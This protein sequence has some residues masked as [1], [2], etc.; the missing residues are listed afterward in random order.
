MNESVTVLAS[1]TWIVLPSVDLMPVLP[2]EWSMF[3]TSEVAFWVLEDGK[4]TLF[5]FSLRVAGDEKGNL[6]GASALTLSGPLM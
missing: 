4:R 2:A 3:S 6:D 1:R 5:F